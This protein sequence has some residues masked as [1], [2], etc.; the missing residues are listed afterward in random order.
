MVT[1]IDESV[2]TSGAYERNF[3]KNG[4]RYGHILSA[5]TGRPVQTDLSSVTI[6]DANGAKA[7]ALCTALFGM[8]E[9]AAQA[10]WSSTQMFTPCFSRPTLKL[11]L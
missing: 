9:K 7:D 4:K 11:L 8:G 6:V 10:F 1:A 5:K 2:I 3:E